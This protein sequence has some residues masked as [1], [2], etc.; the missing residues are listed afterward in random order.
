[1]TKP[2]ELVRGS[3][4]HQIMAELERYPDSWFRW[5]QFPEL[6]DVNRVTIQKAFSRLISDGM[7]D[8]R[9]VLDFD[10]SASASSRRPHG[11]HYREIRHRPE[12]ES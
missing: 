4:R 9:M 1:M 2:L 6:T 3:T 7:V 5:Y 10:E 12:K 11:F 8:R